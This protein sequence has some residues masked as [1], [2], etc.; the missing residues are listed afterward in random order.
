MKHRLIGGVSEN[1]REEP[2][3][4]EVH[5]GRAL[6]EKDWARILELAGFPESF[7][8]L[9]WQRAA[10]E[11][12]VGGRPFFFLAGRR[13]GRSTVLKLLS[14]ADREFGGGE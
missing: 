11:A 13:A 3:T 4:S 6:E 5:G 12:F 7:V 10:V 9:P 14:A 1:E 2:V 8:P